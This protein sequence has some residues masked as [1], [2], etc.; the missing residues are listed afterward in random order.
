[1]ETSESSIVDPGS[2]L[3][4]LILKE[5]HRWPRPSWRG[6][7]RTLGSVALVLKDGRRSFITLDPL[8]S[9]R[10]VSFAR[11]FVP[12]LLMHHLSSFSCFFSL[13]SNPTTVDTVLAIIWCPAYTTPK[14]PPFTHPVSFLLSV[15][16]DTSLSIS[17]CLSG[18]HRS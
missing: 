17:H 8:P 11:C 4:Y 7:Y 12:H 2:I 3:S 18:N 13:A 16:G 14:P 1:M 10:P 5:E 15:K 9:R 6:I